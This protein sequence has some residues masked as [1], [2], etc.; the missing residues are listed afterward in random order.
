MR[1]VHQPTTALLVFPAGKLQLIVDMDG[2]LVYQADMGKLDKQVEATQKK[3]DK[4]WARHE[5]AVKQQADKEEVERCETAS[6]KYHYRIKR[7]K[8]EKQLCSIVRTRT[9]GAAPGCL[10]QDV[11]DGTVAALNDAASTHLG[12]EMAKDKKHYEF[13]HR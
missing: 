11:I 12:D 2:T 6:N 4:A 3:F 9:K 13:S 7:L 5:D 1:A 10:A 8:L